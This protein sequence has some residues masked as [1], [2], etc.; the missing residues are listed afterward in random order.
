[1]G[2]KLNDILNRLPAVEVIGN[3]NKV[4][5]AV[6]SPTKKDIDEG[7][8]MWISEKNIDLLKEI[9]LV[10]QSFVVRQ[11]GITLNRLVLIC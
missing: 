8:I 6:V 4:I 5:T 11:P 10:V 7:E 3:T 2:I 9:N 1:M